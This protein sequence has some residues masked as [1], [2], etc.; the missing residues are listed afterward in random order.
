MDAVYIANIGCLCLIN[1]G[2][3]TALSYGFYRQKEFNNKSP[4]LVAFVDFGHSKLTVTFV[5]FGPEKAKIINVYSNRNLGARNID[6]ILLHKF[7][8]EFK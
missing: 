2:S 1:E 8:E 7:C 6:L 5:L 4:R 3:A